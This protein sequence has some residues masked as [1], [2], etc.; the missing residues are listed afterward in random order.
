MLRNFFI[1]LFIIFSPNLF[2]QT[3]SQEIPDSSRDQ[4]ELDTN[5]F[6]PQF[7]GLTFN[8]TGIYHTDSPPFDHSSTEEDQ[9]IYDSSYYL[10]NEGPSEK[11]Y[12][13]YFSLACA[14]WKLNKSEAAK[15]MF[16]KILNSKDSFYTY[17][18]YHSSDIP[19]DTT[20]NTYGYGNFTSSYKHSACMYLTKI[21]IEQ[22][23]F[24]NAL[25]CLEAAVRKYEVVYNCGTGYSFQQEEYR[26]LYGLCYEG[27]GENKKVISLLLPFIFSG[28]N[29][30]SLIRVIR[31]EYSKNQIRYYLQKAINSI[32]CTVDKK[33]SSSFI[34]ANMGEENEKR[35][36][37]K[38][39]SGTGTINL[40]NRI[41][42][43][44][45]PFL[46]DGER[47]TRKYYVDLF[48]NSGISTYLLGESFD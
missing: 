18:Y 24:P 41:I 21:N 10:I 34:Y 48:K 8:F 43:L 40:F 16:L 4:L 23:K 6:N 2:G 17:T 35:T 32:R 36:E 27:L 22:R 28:G 33:P 37:T 29:S 26:Y 3:T 42:T 31:K 44:P 15:R 45:S 14:L 20:H 30:E 5:I 19:G 38:Y 25:A 13:T 46:K 7:I 9:H 47:L 1:L 39:Y 11:N 12:E